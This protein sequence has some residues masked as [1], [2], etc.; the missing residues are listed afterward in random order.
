[1]KTL[2]SRSRNA[3]TLIELLVVMAIIAILA[4]MLLP[5]LRSTKEAANGVKCMSNL[6]QLGVCLRLYTTDYN[7]V[8]PTAYPRCPNWPGY[9]PGSTVPDAYRATW[10]GTLYDLNYCRNIALMK[11][12]SDR[13]LLSNGGTGHGAYSFDD[14]SYDYNY[15]AFGRWGLHSVEDPYYYGPFRRY[16]EVTHPAQT[17]WAGDNSDVPG[18]SGN[19]LY[20]NFADG[21]TIRHKGGLNMLWVD[22][23]VSWL[24]INDYV[25]HGY[26]AYL[27]FPPPLPERWDDLN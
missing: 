7:N 9:C 2:D 25:L 22:G 5:A 26:Y 23:H 4:A 12:P 1:M 8:V 24:S 18:V 14:T 16:T 19:M 27:Y 11:C 21:L 13:V 20:E 3:F 15:W 6:R 17:Y 10:L